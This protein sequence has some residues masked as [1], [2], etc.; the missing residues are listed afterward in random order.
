MTRFFGWFHP[1]AHSSTTARRTGRSPS[2]FAR[3]AAKFQPDFGVLEA[4]RLLSMDSILA[5]NDVMLQAEAKDYATPNPE[6]G[7]PV[8]AARAFAIVSAAMYDAYNSIE[9]IGAPYLV[10]APRADHADSD[11]ATSQAAHDTLVALFPAQKRFFD[12]ALNASLRRIRDGIGEYQ[13][14]RVGAYV[15]QQILLARADDGA[16]EID[17]PPYRPNGRP[18]FYAADPLHPYQAAYGS[19]AGGIKPFAVRTTDQF[20]ARRLDDGTPAGRAEFLKSREYT[21]AY[22]EV[23]NL[24][25]ARSTKRT[26]EQTIIGV[27][28][29]YDGRPGLG[30]PPRLYNQI[31]RTI[32]IQQGNTEAENARLFALVNIAMAD[33]SLTCW[34]DKYDE[35]FWRPITAVR[36]GDQDGN[37]WTRGDSDWTPLG[38][39]AS[40]PYPGETNFTPPFPAYTSGHATIGAAAFQTLTRFYGRDDIAFSF[41]SDEFNGVTVGSDGKV[42][43]VV[44]R[45]YDSFTQAKIENAQ[46]RIYLG[47]HWAFDR[48]EGIR[49]GDRVANY[50]FDTI[51]TPSCH[52]WDWDFDSWRTDPS[53]AAD[54][55]PWGGDATS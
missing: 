17:T 50:V 14:R 1:S 13:G 38:A 39:P 54:S 37:P 27:F 8:L 53:A 10:T 19:G 16:S 4:R 6:Q 45:S 24:G 42:R 23:S 55:D 31:V 30:T 25:G 20:A 44:T 47:I 52:R 2:S 46:S 32:A 7:G 36:D 28:W 11:A 40:N 3:Q 9:H 18:G 29:G 49:C 33:A 51:L 15:A 5:W 22:Q 21:A 12:A 41:T 43:P 48:D 35:D 26:A 34:D